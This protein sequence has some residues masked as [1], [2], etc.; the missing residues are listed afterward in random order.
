M[1]LQPSICRPANSRPRSFAA[2]L[3]ATP[4]SAPN[5]QP[6]SASSSAY[7]TS[8]K[9]SPPAPVP[10]LGA[11]AQALKLID[12]AQARRLA[13]AQSAAQ[14]TQSPAATPPKIGTA[15]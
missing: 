5:S 9:F 10:P 11:V 6:P 1:S 4:K 14:P 15:L 8:D 7:A 2:P 12:Q 13:L 3:P